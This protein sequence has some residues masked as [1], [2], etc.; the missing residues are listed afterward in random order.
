MRVFITGGSGFIGGG[1]VKALVAAGHTVTGLARFK[2]SAVKLENLGAVAAYGDISEPETYH[3][4]AAN[5]DALVHAAFDYNAG[6]AAGILTDRKTTEI[7]LEAARLRPHPSQ[8]IYT[9]SAFLLGNLGAIPASE[10]TI[11]EN[12]ANLHAWRFKHEDLVLSAN[13]EKLKTAVVRVGMVYGGSGGIM[14]EQ[15]NIAESSEPVPYIENG[16]QCYPMVHLND[17]AQLYRLII[18]QKLSGIFHGVDGLAVTAKD[19]ATTVSKSAGKN[20]GICRLNIEEARERWGTSADILA[21]DVRVA[22]PRTT[23]LGWNLQYDSFVE[24]S[25]LAFLNYREE[26]IKFNQSTKESSY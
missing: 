8:V 16:N 21:Q 26:M 17:L 23:E 14:G 9:S 18:E 6:D 3:G 5:H 11:V 15:F 12:P 25:D 10:E 22:A 20:S 2:E 13:T 19:I 1:I 7:L 24:N 4:I